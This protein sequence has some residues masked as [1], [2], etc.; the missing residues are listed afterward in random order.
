MTDESDPLADI[1][2]VFKATEPKP[3]RKWTASQHVAN[4]KRA[5][6]M[7]AARKKKQDRIEKAALALPHRD[8]KPKPTR[9]RIADPPA[10]PAPVL[11]ERRKNGQQVKMMASTKVTHRAMA[12]MLHISIPELKKEYARELA[13]GPEFVYA[14]VSLRLVNAA[15]GGEF[16]SMYSWL[17][18][19]GGWNEVSRK[20]ITGKDGGPISFRNL[21]DASLTAVLNALKAPGNVS[22]GAG[23]N[24]SSFGI[25]IEGATDLD[26]ISG[27]SDE[28]D[29]E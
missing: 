1:A 28:G 16:R 7:R 20:E 12:E 18:Q 25:D 9:I 24:G 3:E 5:A 8:P 23:R 17:R 13:L 27:P 19:F 15:M 29:A 11:S 26:A 2:A 4:A 14:A 22:R 10:M 21:D 6:K